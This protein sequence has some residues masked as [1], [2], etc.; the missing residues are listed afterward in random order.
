MIKKIYGF[1]LLILC[2]VVFTAC[3]NGTI[4]FEWLKVKSSYTI[5]GTDSST[6]DKGYRCGL[7]WNKTDLLWECAE[8]SITQ[9][10]NTLFFFNPTDIVID[11]I[12]NLIPWWRFNYKIT[13]NEV[14]DFSSF[15]VDN[16]TISADILYVKTTEGCYLLVTER[17]K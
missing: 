11:S 10:E 9:E 2:T 15:N 14:V 4:K 1:F 6:R 13:K 7:I 3:D 12:N 16:E 5:L 8:K 17:F